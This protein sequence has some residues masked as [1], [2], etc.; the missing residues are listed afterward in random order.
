MPYEIEF[1]IPLSLNHPLWHEDWKQNWCSHT[2]KV[3]TP[4]FQPW[5]CVALNSA[6]YPLF[7]NV[8]KFRTEVS[9]PIEQVISCSKMTQRMNRIRLYNSFSCS[10]R[11][12]SSDSCIPKSS[13]INMMMSWPS[14]ALFWPREYWMQVNDFKSSRFIYLFKLNLMK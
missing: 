11:W 14:L 6:P 3:L 7:W 4:W 10:F 2:R 8:A 12:I 9:L 1:N 5:N 13:M